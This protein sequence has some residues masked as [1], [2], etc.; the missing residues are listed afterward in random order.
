MTMDNNELVELFQKERHLQDGTKRVYGNAIKH[1]SKLNKMSMHELIREAEEDEENRIRW[2]KRRI[3]QRLINYREYLNRKLLK[4]T[5]RMYLE[6]II[7]VYKHFEIE[8]HA[9]PHY[10]DRNL[11]QNPPITFED[12]PDR[13]LIKRVLSTVNP[14]L[15]AV[16]LF[17]SSSGCAMK[18]TCNLTIQ[19]FI[20]A[21][22]EYHNGGEITD[23]LITLNKNTNSIIPTFKLR[24]QKTN[25]YYYTFCSPEAAASII[26]FLLNAKWK[27]TPETKLFK[28][29]PATLLKHFQRMNDELMLG[30]KGT[31][32]RFTSH[33][34][35]KYHATTLANTGRL[36]EAEI[37]FL[38][39]RTR[40]QLD[41]IYL[42]QDPRKLR[43]RYVDCL[44]DLMI[45]WESN[46]VA[47]EEYDKKVREKEELER[48]VRVQEDRLSHVESLLSSKSLDEWFEILNH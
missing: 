10:S 33:M 3:R 24:R 23:I 4:T 45:Y 38:Q 39:G 41:E 35:R 26:G 47:R 8:I 2:K 16:I 11:K 40:G 14:H 7:T 22:K 31:K 19:E 42:L 29:V 6:R 34:L 32:R 48:V 20:E 44:D 36:S 27:L 18:E 28:V 21:T 5:A 1:Y 43:E 17:M 46:G 12:I 13:E 15:R 37:H 30:R 9:L 25:K